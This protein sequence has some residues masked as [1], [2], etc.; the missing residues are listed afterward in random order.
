MHGFTQ[1][2]RYALRGLRKNPSFTI[3]A[4][5]T[6]ALGIGA[7]TAI[8]SVLNAVLLRPLP[9]HAP[10]QLAM[11]WTEIP[12]Q[13]LR[14]GR[15]AYGDVE[16]W[17]RQSQTFADM[18]VTDPVR[19]TLTTLTGSEQIRVSRISS[20]YFSLLGVR[21]AYG[22]TFSEKE[23]GERQRLALISHNFW[24]ARF[25]GSGDAI[26]ASLVI[27]G[28]PSRIIGVLPAELQFDDTEVWEPHTLFPDWETLRRARGAG[29]WF[30]VAR[31]RP[32]V[33]FQQA[34]TEMNAIARRLDE[35]SPASSQRGI[36]VMPLTLYVTAPSTRLAL[37]MLTAAV[38]F[39]LI[40]AIAN[41]AGLSLARSAGRDRE[42][43]IRSALGAS[44]THIVRQLMVESVTLAVLSGIASL[45]VALAGIRL[46]LSLRPGGLVR[47][48]EVRLDPWGFGW[49]L[50]LSLLSGV[51]IGLAPAITTL[52]RNLKPAFQEG[53]R[54]ASGSAATRRVRRVLVVAEFA[55]AI[56]LLVGAGLLTRSLL[57]VQNVDP[58]FSTKQ[59]LSLQLASPMFPTP[60][61]R[62]NY[63]ERVLEETK[64]VAGVEK[65][66]IAS[67][68]FIGGNPDQFVM[69]EGSTRPAP[70]RMRFRRDEIT[71]DFFETVGTPVL[72]GRTFSA[73]DGAN[74]PKVAIINDMMARRLWPG[75]DAVG[76]RFKLGSADA[77]SPWFTVVGVVGDMRRQGP[78]QDP[79][80]QMFESLAQ[81]PSRLVTL[82]VRT[83]ADPSRMVAGVQA[84]ARQVE[85]GAPVYGATTLEDRL[86]RFHEQRRFQT[87]LLIAFALVALLLAAVGIYGLIRFSI[88][89][90][91]R[92]ISIRIAV[93]AQRS[94]IFRMILREGLTLSIIGL[95]LGLV[96][97]VWL[98]RL[99]S[100][101]V[102]GITVADPVTF[103]AVSALLTAVAAAACYMPARRAGRINPI[104]ALKYE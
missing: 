62:V 73:A 88:A 47:M 10:E 56:M 64:A 36:S 75:Q 70:E 86:N 72:R 35:Q 20:N 6:L 18:A 41:V 25:G 92:E 95:A 40:M 29:S 21:P 68:F 63:F 71:A 15:S 61:Q 48:D 83:S 82:L 31:L 66:A 51:L 74:A 28:L 50:T 22:R 77:N 44:Q 30:V 58:G 23:A 84:A 59:V 1:D 96:G 13:A 43:A 90:R 65:A 81:N 27:D 55:L 99:L 9:Y 45:F 26:G 32:G 57:N 79:I 14:Q 60:A 38:S 37:W 4:V 54:G 80:P 76:R 93:G 102:F 46:I 7:N 5:L 39:V 53:G 3:V 69:V 17:R 85:K 34:Q 87:S 49:A 12:T 91:M 11:L 52:R 67:E 42:I 2:L 8:F 19:P 100:G 98:G 78:E 89:T 16:E 103:V 94:D 24:Q 97:A 101:L 104:V 33:T